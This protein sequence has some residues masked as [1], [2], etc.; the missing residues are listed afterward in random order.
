M[1]H[2]TT[3]CSNPRASSFLAGNLI[4]THALATQVFLSHQQASRNVP[5]PKA[6]ANL[7]SNH[8]NLPGRSRALGLLLCSMFNTCSSWSAIRLESPVSF[9]SHRSC[10]PTAH[11]AFGPL[12]RLEGKDTGMS[13]A[14][15]D[16]VILHLSRCSLWA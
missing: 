5:S 13:R 10:L 8:S 2:F 15:L 1:L 11:G 7:V 16:K 9:T 14:N 6:S 3:P 4:T 12:G